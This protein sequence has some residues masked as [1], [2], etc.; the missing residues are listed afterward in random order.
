MTDITHGKILKDLRVSELK[1]ELEKRGLPTSGLKALLVERL[2]KQLEEDGFD[3]EVFDFS[4]VGED[5]K[6]VETRE[7]TTESVTDKLIPEGKLE[8]EKYMQLEDNNMPDGISASEENSTGKAD[9]EKGKVFEKDSVDVD[10]IQCKESTT[11]NSHSTQIDD[12]IEK[13][14][15]D[16]GTAHKL[17]GESHP[18]D[19]DSINLMIGEDEENLMY[20]DEQ[21]N[22]NGIASSPPRP[23]NAPVVNPFTS[24]DTISMGASR[25]NDAPSDNSSMLVHL[26][27]TESVATQLSGEGINTKEENQQNGEKSEKP[28]ESEKTEGISS[29]SSTVE[30]KAGD[31]K[32]EEKQSSSGLNLWVSGLSSS[33]RATDLKTA[34]SKHGKVVGAKVVTNARTPG[35]KCYGYVSMGS[36]EDADKCIKEL[37]KT[38]LHGRVILVEK[39]RSDSSGPP[40]AITKDDKSKKDDLS[41]SSKTEE[42]AEDGSSSRDEASTSTKKDNPSSKSNEGGSDVSK[43]EEDKKRDGPRSSSRGTSN[44]EN[45]GDKER[46][47]PRR[48]DEDRDR[49]RQRDRDRDRVRRPRSPPRG[50][51]HADLRN[52]IHSRDRSPDRRNYGVD[53]RRGIQGGGERDNRHI[54]G[55]NI[56]PPRR[57]SPP[58]E[59]R[60]SPNSNMDLSPRRQDR[61]DP[62]R[63]GILTFSQIREQQQRE[64]DREVERRRRA[65]ERQEQIMV[66]E[67]RRKEDEHRRAEDERLHRE[68]EEIRRE[69]EKIE[70][71]KQEILK[72]ERDRQRQERDRLQKEKEELEKLRRQQQNRLEEARRATKRPAAIDERDPYYDDRKRR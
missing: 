39:A 56:S 49:E 33:T 17:P 62:G 37:H 44:T 10:S 47:E 12:K 53:A 16:S 45:R 68:R 31:S 65:R 35:A 61:P 51:E 55:N 41:N 28:M 64:K 9:T 57:R 26:D 59:R 69:R 18:G 3:P 34:F 19:E 14:K 36:T 60:R 54:R 24:R 38:E 13:N 66:E 2:Q 72:F 40:R 7:S 11:E 8:N 20:D 46:R 27:E 52:R 22:K 25:K 1:E 4:S 43:Q 15:H 70:R 67:R 23:E 58:R 48:R 21:E 6:E 32:C 5:R 30:D 63:P 42:Q 29:V 50:R 71:E